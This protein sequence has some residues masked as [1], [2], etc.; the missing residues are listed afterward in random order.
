MSTHLRSAE[1]RRGSRRQ[2]EASRTALLKAALA[3][4]AQE[5]LAG[6]RVDA[7]ADNAGVNKALL[8]Y[9]FHDKETLY[10]ATLENFFAPLHQRIMDACDRPGSAGGTLFWCIPPHVPFST[11]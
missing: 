7:I 11:C 3:E 4:F 9:Y 8:Y 5:G 6:P 10:G 1:P 2:P